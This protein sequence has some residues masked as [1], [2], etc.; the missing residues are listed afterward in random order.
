MAKPSDEVLV[1]RCFAQKVSQNSTLLIIINKGG[2]RLLEGEI[3]GFCC[4][5]RL[6]ACKLYGSDEVGRVNLC[7]FSLLCRCKKPR[8][9]MQMGLGTRKRRLFLLECVSNLSLRR[10]CLLWRSQIPCNLSYTTTLQ[11]HRPTSK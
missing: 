2:V 1:P 5:I 4:R 10:T 6:K 11:I 9:I 3:G 8:M 7:F